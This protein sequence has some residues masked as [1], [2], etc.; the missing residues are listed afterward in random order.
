MEL[1]GSEISENSS[2]T[3]KQTSNRAKLNSNF[4]MKKHIN[5]VNCSSSSESEQ[6]DLV[7]PNASDES[8]SSDQVSYCNL[9]LT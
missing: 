4:V 1:R 2:M 5:A 6:S 7:Q 9:C 8:Q 3:S